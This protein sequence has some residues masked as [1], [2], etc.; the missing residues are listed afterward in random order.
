MRIVTL[1]T[2]IAMPAG[3]LYTEYEPCIFGE[4]QIKGESCAQNDWFVQSIVGSL[5]VTGSSE[6]MEFLLAEPAAGKSLPIDLES[7][8]RNGLFPGPESLYA[9]WEPQDV[10]QLIARLMLCLPENAPA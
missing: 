1:E 7:Q 3:T 2:F 8:G 6:W 4:L 5:D 10:R 9:V